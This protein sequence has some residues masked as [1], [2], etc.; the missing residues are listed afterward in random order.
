MFQDIFSKFRSDWRSV[1]SLVV[2]TVLPG[3]ANAVRPMVDVGGKNSFFIQGDGALWAWGDNEDGKLGD[4]TDISSGV[5]KKIGFFA[6]VSAGPMNTAAIQADSTLWAWGANSY[7]G[8]GDFYDATTFRPRK[9]GSGF[10]SVAVNGHSLREYAVAIKTD[11]TLWAWGRNS[12]G[13]MGSSTIVPAYAP[14]LMGTGFASASVG[15]EHTVALKTDGNLWAWGN[16]S[17]GQLGDGTNIHSSVAKLVGSHF[18]GVSAGGEHTVALKTDGT[19][20]A[21][22]RNNFGQIGDGTTVDSNSPKLIAT[23]F[24]SVVAGTN[25]TFA[26]KADGSLWAWGANFSGSLGDGSLSVSAVPKKIGYDFVSVSSGL[27]HTIALKTDGSVWAWGDNAKGQLGDGSVVESVMPKKII[28]GLA[29]GENIAACI[30]GWAERNFSGF[31]PVAGSV[32]GS[33]EGYVYRYYPNSGNYLGRS[34]S[35][36]HILVFGPSSRNELLDLGS[37]DTWA[38]TAGCH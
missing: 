27:H 28:P 26:I 25:N 16:N 1:A 22:G 32:A 13:Q 31:F 15:A 11:T 23:G 9:I 5:P 14:K 38:A 24:V 8:P 6:T 35:S 29:S 19:L 34:Q 37:M 10:A 7:S 4:G 12:S 20:W 3:W 36:N 2:L 30:F 21:W 33:L 18:I 17:Y